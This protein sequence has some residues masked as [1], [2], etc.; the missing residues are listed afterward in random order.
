MSSQ[1]S[2]RRQRNQSR[3]NPRRRARLEQERRSAMPQE[4]RSSRVV[5]LS[6]LAPIIV[7]SGRP[8]NALGGGVDPARFP[9]PSTIAGCLLTAWA[10]AADIPFTVD[11]A[12]HGIAG[13][14]LIDCRNQVM[15]PKPVDALYF[16]DG[17]GSNSAQCVRAQPKPLPADSGMD[18]PQGLLPVQLDC[19]VAGKPANGT[20]WW[21]LD[22]LIRFRS[23]KDIAFDELQR[24]GWSPSRDRRTHIAIDA[25]TGVAQTGELFQTEG[26]DLDAA[27]PG[28]FRLAAHSNDGVSDAPD[29]ETAGQLRLLAR[30]DEKLAPCLVHLGGKR[31]LAG[32]DAESEEIWPQPP[33]N[34]AEA[35]CRAGGLCVTTLTPA[36]FS[37]GY[38]PGW[39]NADFCGSPPEC[40]ALRLR[41][42]AAAVSRWEPHSGWDLQRQQ[43]RPTRKLV[44]AGAVYWF[45]ILDGS[46]DDMA[47]LWLTNLS[48]DP[49]DRL[50]GFGLAMPAP[51]TP[52]DCD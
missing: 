40:P 41:L 42:R 45:R 38:R 14:L 34:W 44:P 39:L 30:F 2:R 29:A 27:P 28:W 33:A 11:L 13:P 47:R 52:D 12:Q 8:F 35:A 6:P 31:R 17:P 49:Q 46:A 25:A 1:R 21:R 48:D 24:T 15:A 19:E 18:L 26:L 37:G 23:G 43:P 10:R 20:R 3:Q 36:I 5:S 4:R 9:P 22:D 16:S 51:W 32:L 7:R 50:D